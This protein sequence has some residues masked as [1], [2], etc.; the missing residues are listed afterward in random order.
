MKIRVFCDLKGNKNY[1]DIDQAYLT[2][3]RRYSKLLHT[4]DIDLVPSYSTRH[5]HVGSTCI[6]NGP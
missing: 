4:Q 6:T 3:N 1:F 5:M 2:L